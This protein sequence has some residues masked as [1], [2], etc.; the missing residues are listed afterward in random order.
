[1]AGA[2]GLNKQTIAEFRANHGQ[3]G[4]QFAG[5]RCCSCTPSARSGQR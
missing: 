4:G 1:M 3:V 2:E 5:R